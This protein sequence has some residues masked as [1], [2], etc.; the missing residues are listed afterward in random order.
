MSMH[1]KPRVL[2]F[3]EVLRCDLNHCATQS[4]PASPCFLAY[5][6]HLPLYLQSTAAAPQVHA[7]AGLRM[8]L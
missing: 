8:A 3:S 5:H 1:I 4:D 6:L 2:A 7:Q